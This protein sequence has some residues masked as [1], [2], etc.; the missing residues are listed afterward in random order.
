MQSTK[1]GLHI[2]VFL[3]QIFYH[4]PKIPLHLNCVKAL[5]IQRSKFVFSNLDRFLSIE[6]TA[7]TR[8]KM[9]LFLE[10]GIIQASEPHSIA[11]EKV[12]PQSNLRACLYSS[13]VR[14]DT[15]GL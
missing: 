15:V 2:S 13:S 5:V 6:S 8:A 9:L 3:S 10:N 12:S 11:Q 1:S 7:L 4:F 14:F